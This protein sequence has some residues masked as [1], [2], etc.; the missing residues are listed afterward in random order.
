MN[1][2]YT[3]PHSPFPYAHLLLS[4]IHLGQ[5]LFYPLALQVFICILIV[6]GGFTSV[7]QACIYYLMPPF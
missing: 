5:D 1:T 3:H 7:L 2:K 6:Q 4:G